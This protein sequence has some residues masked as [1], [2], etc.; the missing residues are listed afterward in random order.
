MNITRKVRAIRSLVPFWFKAAA[1]GEDH[2][3]ESLADIAFSYPGVVPMQVRSELLEFAALVQERRPKALIEIGT[4]NGGTFFV[5][6]RLAH[7]H[8][9]V[10]SLDLPGGKF[11]GGYTIFQAPVINH[12]KQSGQQLQLLR[13]DSHHPS[14]RT[15][16][17]RALDHTPLDLLFIDGD[18]TY[19][20]VKRDF[21]MYSPLMAP[22]GLIAFHDIVDTLDENCHV[23]RFWREV[24]TRYPHREIVEDE[25]QGWGG[26]GVLFT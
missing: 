26:I 25:R 4:R 11:G 8:A 9:K 18:H 5:L 2:S 13:R 3:P 14:T 7:P 1:H 6:C 20:G 16:V 21:E 17:V 10:I 23:N 22:G 24:K 19:D 12:M 15:R